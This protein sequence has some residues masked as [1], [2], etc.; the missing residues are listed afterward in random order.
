MRYSIAHDGPATKAP[1]TPSALPAVFIETN[2]SSGDPV[3]LDQAAPA[4]A[5][6]ADRVRLVHDEGGAGRSAERRVFDERRD[7]AVHAEERLGD[8]E[9]LPAAAML[10]EETRELARRRCAE[11]RRA[12]RRTA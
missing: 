4:R 7:V 1:L 5:V 10:G 8:D 12:A 6:D 2:T 9:H 3:R 11:T